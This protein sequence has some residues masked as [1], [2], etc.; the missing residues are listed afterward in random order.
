MRNKTWL[1]FP[2]LLLALA[3][4]AWLFVPQPR[5]GAQGPE[6]N[7]PTGG[8]ELTDLLDAGPP[9]DVAWEAS[10][11]PDEQAPR[12][13]EGQVG[14][15]SHTTS[16]TYQGRLLD[17]GQPAD[18]PYDV[19][20]IL[21]DAESGGSQVGGTIIKDDAA[22]SDGL[23]TVIL[24]FGSNTFTG[25]ARYL[26]IA[27]RPGGSTG[28]FAVLSPR[29]PVTATPYATHAYNADL[30]DGRDSSTFA[31]SSHSHDDRYY[32]KLSGTQFTGTLN[33]GQSATWFTFNW[34]TDEIMYWSVHP[35]TTDGR[36]NWTVDIRLTS[37]DRFTYYL[38]IRN[39]GS[40]TT[41]FQ[42]KYIRFR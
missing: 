7:D 12:A 10:Q 21:Y 5:A 33:A 42:A 35:T 40:S 18:G 17:N 31:S 11:S 30:L 26:E 27:V 14:I 13:P 24:D 39:T 2:V 34:P 3:L 38:T 9:A 41:S 36:V 15:A 23:F 1:T 20:F 37:N 25:S 22:V 19:R 28:A 29:R 32:R 4:G 6:G 16:F 8:L